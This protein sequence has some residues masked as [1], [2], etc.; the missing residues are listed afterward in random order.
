[1]RK[2]LLATGVCISIV[3]MCHADGANA[4]MTRMQTSIPSQ[5]LGPALKKFAQSRDMQVLYFTAQVKDLRTS[6]ASGDLTADEALSRLLTGTGLTYRYIDANAVT[7]IPVGAAAAQPADPPANPLSRAGGHADE[8]AAQRKEGKSDSSGPF[9]LAQVAG[10][11]SPG[12]PAV[13]ALPA[14]ADNTSLQEVVVTGSRFQT[15]NASSPAPVTIVGAADFLHQGTAKV[16]DLLNTLPQVNTGLTDTAYGAGVFPL[17]GTA[18]VDLRGIG[19]FRTLVLMNGRR[20]NPGDAVN[21]SADLH[22]IPE[23]LIKRVEVLTGG[24]SA[25]YGSDAI[26]GV[27]N[28]VMDDRFVGTK[29]VVQGNGYYGTNDNM[30]V[31]N[32]LLAS[33]VSAP[34]GNVFDGKTVNVSA[35]YG[36]N[37]AGGAGHIE[38]YAGYRHNGG[39]LRSSRDFSACTLAEAGSSYSCLLDGTTP[40]GQFV[41][42]SGASYTLAAGGTM[43]P[44]DPAKNAYNPASLQSMLSPDTRYDAGVFG[45]YRFNDHAQGYL[46]AQLTDDHTIVQYEMSGTSPT[47]AGPGG[48]FSVPCND[49]LLT[50]DEVNV[51][52]TRNGL[53]ATD[54]AQVMIGRRNIEGGPV[55]DSF[56]HSSYRMVLGLKGE[57]NDAWTYDGSVNYGKVTAHERLSNDFSI[58]RL[59]NALDVVSVNGKPTCQSVVDGSGPGC[60]P[61]NI[62]SPGGVTPAALGYVTQGGT[63]DG[64]ATQ[65]VADIQ[66]VG[67]LG[68]Y[69]LKSPWAVDGLGLAAGAEYRDEVINTHPSQSYITNDLV[70]ASA[71]GLVQTKPAAGSFHVSEAF[72]ELKVPLLKD[73]PLAQSLNLD[74]ADRIAEYSPQGTANA[75]NFGADWAPIRTVRFRSSYSRAIRA[76][77]GHELFLAQ[78]TT[79]GNFADPCSG[80]TPTAT[81]AQC[82]LTGV[83][84]AQ[85]GN[86]PAATQ[87][88]VLQGGN[89]KL[90]PE[91]A[92]TFTA[93]VVLTNFE[94]APSL[95]LSVDYWRIRIKQ[96]LGSIPA[97]TTLSSCLASGNPTFCGLVVRDA[98]GSLATTGSG[99]IVQ[100]NINTGSYGESGIDVAGQ[101]TLPLRSAGAVTLTFNGTKAIDNPIVVYPT[102]SVLDCIDLYGPSCTGS[103]P[104]S[105]VPNWRHSLRATWSLKKLEVSLNWRYIGSMSFE[106]TSQYSSVNGE[107][108]FPVDAHVGSYSYFD[109]DTGYDLTSS[110]N[111]HLGVN[112]LLNK[113]PALV[114]YSSNP[115][116]VNGNVLAGMY[117]PFGREIFAELTARF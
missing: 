6:G 22:T 114:G 50:A 83:T 34:T 16:E 54:T 112:N 59:A 70:V 20:V 65:A 98:A 101:Y 97:A 11:A 75:Y 85:Y 51:F 104:T 72:A 39:I 9:L 53:A 4:A 60:V 8:T 55:Q 92:N 13:A 62:W 46:E 84:A 14:G 40:S 96:Y 68:Q 57:I 100:T 44:Y 21:P 111:V 30:G 7:I 18:T 116:L 43:R 49:P 74:L 25:I 52:C 88:R 80:P 38:A 42:P 29:L 28:F 3:G 47:G 69:G 5:A 64:Y 109:L 102:A 117:D 48:P 110:V 17:T 37:F 73:K 107:T 1:M 81:Q 95:L 87:V 86:I 90:R 26:A 2:S 108:V 76:P 67:D 36:T 115:G 78:Q 66:A 77:N 99:Y 12:S 94:W 23:A 24:A 58:S 103:G 91:V 33:G 45:Q 93:G 61:Y 27:V 113:Q 71:A 32:T 35:A 82:A 63:N 89:P 41:S 10:G 31:R 79:A 15:P 56:R 106:G 105:P 19:A